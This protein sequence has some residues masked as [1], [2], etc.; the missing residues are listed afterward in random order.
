M[1]APTV[2]LTE[3]IGLTNIAVADTGAETWTGYRDSGGGTPTPQN[4]TDIFIQGS[5]AVSIKVS[6]S[7]RDEGVWYDNTTGVDMTVSGRHFYAWALV[8]TMSQITPMI[9]NGTASITAN[10]CT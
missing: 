1:A 7:T 10:G 9:A 2:V 5:Q 8:T 4:E 6:G 3:S